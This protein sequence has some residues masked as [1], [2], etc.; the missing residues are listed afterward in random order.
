MMQ[1][2]R[3]LGQGITGGDG[4]VM[5][6]DRLT[7]WTGADVWCLALGYGLQLFFDFAGYTHIAAGAAKV[8]GF[9]VPEK[10]VRPFESTSPSEF[11]TRWHMSLSFWIRDYLFFP[12]AASRRERAWHYLALLISMIVFGLWHRA[13]V[14][15]LVW[16]C[17]HGLLLIAHRQLQQVSR[18]FAREPMGNFWTPF[19]WLATTMFISLGWIF[20]RANSLSQAHDMLSAIMSLTSYRAHFLSLNAYVLVTLVAAGYLVV[21]LVRWR[22]DAYAHVGP[23]PAPSPGMVTRIA[24]WRWFWIPPL[25]AFALLLVLMIMSDQG[26]GAAQLIYRG[27]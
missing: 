22:L 15:F 19:K 14:L 23:S 10:F 27:F 20:F 7:R 16:G 5:G 12:L 8:L 13:S 17:Y 4:I 11:W 21:L 18:K 26:G 2:A 3:L 6:F 25:Y 24:H 1:V 9:S